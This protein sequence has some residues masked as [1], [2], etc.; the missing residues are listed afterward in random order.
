MC[1]P[2][3][4]QNRNDGTALPAHGQ[5]DGRRHNDSCCS[6][7]RARPAEGRIVRRTRSDGRLRLASLGRVGARH[8][9]DRLTPM[10]T[11]DVTAEPMTSRATHDVIAARRVVGRTGRD[12]LL[13]LATPIHHHALGRRVLPIAI[14]LQ[15]ATNELSQ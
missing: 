15:N 11:H 5:R 9:V 4:A 8:D 3:W 13:A 14:H 2:C 12:I 1:R 7:C 6:G 10:T